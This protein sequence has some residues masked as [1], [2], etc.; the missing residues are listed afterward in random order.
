L[1]DTVHLQGIRVSV[2][3]IIPEDR[4]S[5]NSFHVVR[6]RSTDFSHTHLNFPAK[7]CTDHVISAC[8]RCDCLA[9]KERFT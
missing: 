1:E 5:F 9:A 3:T 4:L 8:F 6:E 7:S 2:K